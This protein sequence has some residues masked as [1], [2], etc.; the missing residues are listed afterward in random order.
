MEKEKNQKKDSIK[1]IFLGNETVGKTALINAYND[2]N[3]TINSMA[4]IGAEFIYKTLKIDEKEYNIQLWD[5]AGQE[6][7]RAV[8]KIYFKGSDIV[9]FVYD[10]TN[11]KTFNDLGE[12][13]IG[14][15]KE[16][17]KDDIVFG[18][19]AN[20]MDLFDSI[21]VEKGVG[22]KLAAD[23]GALFC[24]TSAKEDSQ[25]FKR[26]V[27]KLVRE[28]ISKKKNKPK[29]QNINLNKNVVKKK[30]KKLLL[31]YIV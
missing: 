23:N 1:V 13:W 19:A 29:E 11:Q 31:N 24:E 25:G 28:Y 18:I 26:F 6:K 3:F 12:F 27:D 21:K 20:K 5:T 10:V 15:V 4:T 22:Q 7:F 8:A 2:K 30:G 16:C 17:I 14:Y 9:I